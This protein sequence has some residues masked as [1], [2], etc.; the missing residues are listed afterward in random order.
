[1]FQ[2]TT[3]FQNLL[4]AVKEVYSMNL[5]A[6]K[7]NVTEIYLRKEIRL[8]T[9]TVKQAWLVCMRACKLQLFAV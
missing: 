9:G 5:Y 3:T 8:P 7:I 1:M 4:A 6:Y 2:N